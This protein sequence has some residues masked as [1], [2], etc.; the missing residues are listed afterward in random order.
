MD[1]LHGSCPSELSSFES[2]LN[3]SLPLIAAVD[4]II[5]AVNTPFLTLVRQSTSNAIVG[6]PMSEVL[7]FS[8]DKGVLTVI[9]RDGTVTYPILDVAKVTISP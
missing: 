4:G 6:R 9:T 5:A 8:V 2:L 7:K 1:T 3:S